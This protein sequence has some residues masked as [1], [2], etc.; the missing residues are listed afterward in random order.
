MFVDPICGQLNGARAP[1]PATNPLMATILK[2]GGFSPRGSYEPP[3][4][5]TPAPVAT[6]LV[7]WMANATP[8]PHPAVFAGPIGLGAVANP[9]HLY[10]NN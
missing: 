6:A 2:G 9:G 5:P 10:T 8:A 4:Q 1:S 3:F 7:G